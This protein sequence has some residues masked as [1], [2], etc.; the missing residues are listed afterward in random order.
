[1]IRDHLAYT[2][3]H[4]IPREMWAGERSSARTHARTVQGSGSVVSTAATAAAARDTV[5]TVPVININGER[6][7]FMGWRWKYVGESRCL[8]DSYL[9][10]SGAGGPATVLDLGDNPG[11]PE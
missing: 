7:I 8:A 3:D 2:M 9:S 6:K 10:L 4:N 5:N 11:F 1:M